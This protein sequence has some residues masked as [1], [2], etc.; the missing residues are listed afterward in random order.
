MTNINYTNITHQD[1]LEDFTTRLQNDERFKN[2]S[3]ASIY[4]LFMEM[5]AGV[6]DMTNF[7]MQRTAEECFID[8]AKLDSSVIKL[9]KNLGYNPI[10]PTPAEAE[11][12]ITI[13]GPLPSAIRPGAVIYF[14]QDETDLVFD[15]NKFKLNT[16]Y[17]YILTE[18]DIRNGQSATWTKTLTY[19]VPQESMNY[20]ELQDVKVYNNSALIPIKIFQGEVK[21]FEIKGVSNFTH[22]GKSYQFYDI[23]DIKFSNW[24]GRRDP[25][26]W[27][28]NIFY[29][30]KS[31]TKVGIGKNVDEALSIENLFDIEDLSIYLNEKLSK[32]DNDI[33]DPYSICS[34]TTNSDKTVR[35][36]FGDGVIVRNGLI[37]ENDNIYIQY[38][39]CEGAKANRIGSKFAELKTNNKFYAT[40]PGGVLDVSN[41]IKI[42][43]NTDITGGLD[44]EDQQS[45]KNNAPL[46][47]SSRDRLITKNDFVSY[48][49]ALSTPLKVKNAIAWGQDE[50]EDLDNSDTIYK[51]LQNIICYCIA[52]SL[53]NTTSSVYY[54]INVLTDTSTNINGTF[55]LYGTST[56][57]IRHLSDFIKMIL[58][59]DSFNATQYNDNPSVQWVKNIKKI[60][61]NAEPKMIINSKLYSLPPIVQY[62]DVVGT[63]SVNSLSK[64]QDYKKKV[65]NKIY[66]WLEYNSNFKNK[67]Y[68]SDIIR[69]FNEQEET[70]SAN[71]DIRVSDI[72]KSK[73]IKYTFDVSKLDI[74]YVY[75]LNPNIPGADNID[76]SK[77]TAYNTITIPKE[78]RNGNIITAEMLENKTLQVMLYLSN[79]KNDGTAFRKQAYNQFTPYTVAEGTE[80][81]AISFYGVSYYADGEKCTNSL[82]SLTVPADNDFYSL[83]SFSTSNAGTYG[84]SSEDVNNIQ[85][86]LTDWIANSSTVTEANRPIHLPYDIQVLNNET[87]KETI[88]RRG[89]VQSTYE[90]Q[91]TERSFWLYF[92]PKIITEFYSS[93]MVDLNNEDINGDLWT[94]I[95]NL[96]YDLYTQMKATFCDSI[97][98]DNNNIVNF[99]MDN[100]IPVIRLNI[101]YK[102]GN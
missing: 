33:K 42:T 70:Q 61:E 41:N 18:D 74:E 12:Q 50:I 47:F 38:L 53:Y 65:E 60:R 24:Y 83:S 95:D 75:S 39:T 68:K 78:D 29:K 66:K 90:K 58:S 48:F 82:L 56:D 7:Y 13:K 49:R 101:T 91:L 94:N 98:D 14:S 32:I 71:L 54:P 89:T 20:L 87:R 97:L 43:L 28:K 100:E 52:G 86:L 62:Y 17:S 72:I 81:F 96:I 27:N 10:R 35:L 76:N 64:L 44:F 9:G 57:Y 69:F 6:C 26:G 51:Y 99:S 67:I 31:W 46:Y 40:C 36:K 8:T 23:D 21:T 2:M 63:V 3:S 25:N 55:S 15:N 73:D 1:L 93:S 30:D 22:L 37:S 85:D 80:T 5:L 79:D 102:Y 77:G 59:F 4:Y 34:L 11:I 92:I 84:L 88:T 45:I 16:D 19:S